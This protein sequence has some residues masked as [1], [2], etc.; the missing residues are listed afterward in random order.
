MAALPYPAGN[1]THRELRRRQPNVDY[2]DQIAPDFAILET[3]HVVQAAQRTLKGKLRRRFNQTAKF[4]ENHS[5]GCYGSKF[6]TQRRNA[7]RDQ[8][9]IYEMNEP[10]N[11]RQV[12]AG[13]CCLSGSIG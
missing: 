13:K 3:L 8:I 1:P 12:I 5:T 2:F 9:G 11:A 10:G 4:R 6:R 7:A